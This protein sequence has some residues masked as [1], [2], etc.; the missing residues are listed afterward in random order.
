MLVNEIIER[1]GT[2]LK[3]MSYVFP[4]ENRKHLQDNNFTYKSFKLSSA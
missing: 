2:E 4:P 3:Q 1:L